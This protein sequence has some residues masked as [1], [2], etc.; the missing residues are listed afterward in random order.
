MFDKETVHR[1]KDISAPEELRERVL[2]LQIEKQ[3]NKGT[4]KRYYKQLCTIAAC[5]VLVIALSIMMFGNDRTALYVSGEEVTGEP[6]MF[7]LPYTASRQAEGDTSITVTIDINVK[8]EA[9]LNVNYGSI[10]TDNKIPAEVLNITDDCIVY[11]TFDSAERANGAE[12]VIKTENK[13]IVYKL[14][15]DD[16]N[17]WS[18]YKK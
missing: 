17:I 14:T 16:N 18:M 15:C 7:S 10:S 8:K 9:E 1:Y 11:W 6:V 4:V 13:K 5:L 12:L 2:A 3:K